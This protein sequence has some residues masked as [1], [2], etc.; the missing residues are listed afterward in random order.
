VLRIA[1]IAVRLLD[2]RTNFTVLTETVDVKVKLQTAVL[3]ARLRAVKLAVESRLASACLIPLMSAI[4]S[5]WLL[6]LPSVLAVLT[7]AADREELAVI[8]LPLS[9]LNTAVMLGVN[10]LN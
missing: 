9:A 2:V 3:L 8:S 1:A 5:N 6:K 4:K 7:A 10:R